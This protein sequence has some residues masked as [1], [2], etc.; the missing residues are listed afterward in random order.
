MIA[1][2]RDCSNYG[3]GTA[4][5]EVGPWDLFERR[6]ILHNHHIWRKVHED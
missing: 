2:K 3:F 4:R 5:F 1:K 6:R